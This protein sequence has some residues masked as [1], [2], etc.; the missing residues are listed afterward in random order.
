LAGNAMQKGAIMNAQLAYAIWTWGTE[1]K[2]QLIAGITD[3]KEVGY[4]YFESVVSLIDTFR[5]RVDEFKAI[6]RENQ[7]YPV[8]FY[9]WQRGDAEDDVESVRRSLDFLAAN[10]IKRMSVQAP[11]KP[12][13]GAARAELD[14]LLTVLER[15]GK[16]AQ[17]YG[18][19]PCLHPHANTQVMYESEIDFIMGRLGPDLLSFGPDTAHLAVGR[20]DP[21]EI[22][23]RYADRIKFV[24]LKDVK[25][26]RQVTVDEGKTKEFEVYSDFLEL[27]EGDV[28]LPG[29]LAVLESVN[30]D[31]YLCIELDSSRYGNKESAAMNM[32]YMRKLAAGA[33]VK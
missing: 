11:G 16:L 21:V 6:V 10:E 3:I 23:R 19:A 17:P 28:D 7:V 25:K 12:G 24:H 4:T 13:G 26:N 9:F 15:I 2:E 27:G 18:I 31:G 22:F 32:A 20:C 8:S 33:L 5:D 1:T 30:Y 29:V 14:Q